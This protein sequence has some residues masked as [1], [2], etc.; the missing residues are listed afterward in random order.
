MGGP[1]LECFSQSYP[2]TNQTPST[3]PHNYAV[4][5]GHFE[6]VANSPVPSVCEQTSY[7]TCA[8]AH[9]H[10]QQGSYGVG[11]PSVLSSLPLHVDVA[12]EVDVG[13]IVI[14]C[15]DVDVGLVKLGVAGPAGHAEQTA[16][17]V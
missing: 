13:A 3:Y 4:G 12:R 6:H 8:S 15:E 5:D 2:A 11:H 10:A 16:S 14:V 1:H 7:G 17:T 9:T